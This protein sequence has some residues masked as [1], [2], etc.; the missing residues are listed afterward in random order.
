[1]MSSVQ[2]KTKRS[3]TGLYFIIKD[4][5]TKWGEGCLRNTIVHEYGNYSESLLKKNHGIL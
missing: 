2:Q 3:L 1:M 5:N 4:Y